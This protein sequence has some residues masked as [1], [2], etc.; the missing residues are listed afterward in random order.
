MIKDYVT[1]L[2][3]KEHLIGEVWKYVFTLP[4]GEALIFEAGQYVIL[5]IGTNYRQYSIMSPTYQKTSFDLVVELFEHG[6]G[7]DFLRNIQ[8]GAQAQFKGPAGVFVLRN[9]PY[10][11]IFLATGT[12]IAPVRSMIMTHLAEKRPG[13]LYLFF[14]LKYHGD[15]YFEHEF[16]ELARNNPQFQYKICL[17]QEQAVEGLGECFATGRVNISLEKLWEA[18]PAGELEY[19]VCGS[20]GAVDSLKDFVIAHGAQQDR[21]FFERFTL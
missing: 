10:N 19:Y 8:V 16:E 5:K 18:Q 11:K 20:K 2:Q 15:V 4:E 21:V 14:G 17:S 9:S 13:N 7:S 1:I 6:V 12:G 3:S